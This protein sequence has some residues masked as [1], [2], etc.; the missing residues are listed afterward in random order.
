V[1]ERVITENVTLADVID[2]AADSS[3]KR[4]SERSQAMS[5]V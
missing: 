5:A 4:G 3:G 1:R 2:A